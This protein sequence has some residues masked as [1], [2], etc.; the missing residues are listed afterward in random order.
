MEATP[1]KSTHGATAFYLTKLSQNNCNLRLTSREKKKKSTWQHRRAKVQCASVRKAH[2]C[3]DQRFFQRLVGFLGF[4]FS[5]NAKLALQKRQKMR[6]K[7]VWLLDFLDIG[8]H[9]PQPE[10]WRQ[11]SDFYWFFGEKWIIGFLKDT[12]RGAK[13]TCWQCSRI[14]KWSAIYKNKSVIKI[15]KR[16][17]GDSRGHTP[18]WP[19]PNNNSEYSAK[20][21]L[22]Q[23]APLQISEW[24]QMESSHPSKQ[25]PREDWTEP[26]K[27]FTSSEHLH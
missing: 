19:S 13:S 23:S 16:W 11:R 7:E 27:T 17:V 15:K 20:P 24:L 6:I 26:Q 5:K 12:Y 4:F 9:S 2:H 14:S 21:H 10:F 25:A 3:L 18:P 8:L 22:R 1:V